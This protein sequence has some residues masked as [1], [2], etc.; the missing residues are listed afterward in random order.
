VSAP[1]DAGDPHGYV[2]LRDALLG[3]EVDLASTGHHAESKIVE[4]AVHFYVGSPSEFL[5]ESRIALLTT[6]DSAHNLPLDLAQ[7]IRT[8]I[9]EID[10]GFRAVRGA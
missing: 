1:I 4:R 10:E 5:G 3:F 8:I 6:L 7:R 2:R 9:A